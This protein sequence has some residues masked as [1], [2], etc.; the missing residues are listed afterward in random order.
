MS[1]LTHLR[2]H[3]LRLVCMATILAGGAFM[4][5]GAVAASAVCQFCATGCPGSL[6]QWCQNQGCG[7]GGSCT[8][9]FCM[10]TDQQT[11]QYSII[12][13]IIT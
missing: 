10:G 7:L 12:C 11:Y 13:P 3:L 6:A 8:Y 2:P 4:S 1:L 5:T 9:E